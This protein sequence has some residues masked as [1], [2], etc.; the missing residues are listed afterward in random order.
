VRLF[1][2]GRK[3]RLDHGSLGEI[4]AVA[5]IAA[6]PTLPEQWGAP[7]SEVDFYDVRSD[8]EA[9]LRRSGT[10]GSFSFVPAQH[11]ALHPGQTARILRDGEPVG[12]IGRLHPEVERRLELTYS[13]IVFEIETESGL[14]AVLPRHAEISRFPAVRRDLAVVVAESVPVQALLDSVRRGAGKLLTSLVVFDIYRGKGITEGFKSVAMG[15]NLQDISRTLTDVETDAV[16]AR[17]VADLQ[18]E[19]SATIRDQ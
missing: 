1:E 11:A 13:A 6:G 18:R 12:W 15:L 10:V 4:G 8:V 19:H 2:I 17:V 5:G 3:F 16:V 9:L 7:A 14:A